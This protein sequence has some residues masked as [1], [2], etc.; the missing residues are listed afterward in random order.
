MRIL[1][2]GGTGYIGSHGEHNPSPYLEKMEIGANNP[3]GRTKEQVEDILADLG[4]ADLR[5]HIALLRYFNPVG[6]HPSGRIGEDP[7][8]I[9]N[10]EDP[11]RRRCRRSHRPLPV[12]LRRVR[13]GIHRVQGRNQLL[14]LGR[15]LAPGLPAVRGRFHQGQPAKYPEYAAKKQL[16]ALDSPPEP[17]AGP[18]RG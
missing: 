12:R 4:A 17:A 13:P 8:G 11:R 5:W 2:T 10:K 3:Y 16:L 14:A 18:Q 15:Q 7:Q 1:V 6:A 9:P